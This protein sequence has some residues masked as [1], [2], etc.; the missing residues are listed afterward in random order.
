MGI[1]A[2]YVLFFVW[3]V[4]PMFRIFRSSYTSG[5]RKVF[6][7]VGTFLPFFVAVILTKLVQMLA[8]TE[9][10]ASAILNSTAGAFILV[11]AF[12]VGG[13]VVLAIYDAIHKKT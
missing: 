3:L 12:L 1:I 7:A 6:W 8:P 11:M 2:G 5:L 13:W 10:W 9:P 4:W